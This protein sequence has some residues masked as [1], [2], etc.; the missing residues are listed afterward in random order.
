MHAV[1]HIVFHVHA[2]Q[3]LSPLQVARAGAP[4]ALG[5]N[6]HPCRALHRCTE[7][8]KVET[9]PPDTINQSGS[10]GNASLCIVHEYLLKG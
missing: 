9:D 2:L 10:I 6:R 4:A 8:R 7:M 3:N 5:A 1:F